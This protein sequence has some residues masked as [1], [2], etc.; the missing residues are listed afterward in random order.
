MMIL[1]NK[2]ILKNWVI[3]PLF[4]KNN[5]YVFVCEELLPVITSLLPSSFSPA[6]SPAPAA[7]ASLAL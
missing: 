1:K 2:S 7:A 6:W 3:N 5:E 4:S